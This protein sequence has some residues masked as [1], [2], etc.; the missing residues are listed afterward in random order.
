MKA[1]KPQIETVFIPVKISIT[2]E[3][4]EEYDMFQNLMGRNVSIPNIVYP[5]SKD[6]RD[7]LSDMMQSIHNIL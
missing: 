5:E 3:T 4:Q 7:E 2:L 6:K 1:T